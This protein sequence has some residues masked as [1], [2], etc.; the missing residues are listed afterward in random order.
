MVAL[1]A[2][3]VGRSRRTIASKDNVRMR[4]KEIA[5]KA[6]GY[7]DVRVNANSGQTLN[8]ILSARYQIVDKQ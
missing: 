5:V 1:C 3:T 6:D 7:L 4:D 2:K 8:T